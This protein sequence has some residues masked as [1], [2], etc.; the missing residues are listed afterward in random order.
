MNPSK[1]ETPCFPPL[2]LLFPLLAIAPWAILLQPGVEYASRRLV[3]RLV[4]PAGLS[5]GLLLPQM[6]NLSR[7]LVLLRFEPRY[8]PRQP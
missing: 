7:R 8:L 5:I 1:V 6:A 4:Q 3:V 2:V